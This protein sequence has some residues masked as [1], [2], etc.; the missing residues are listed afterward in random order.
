MVWGTLSN[1]A[2]GG[3]DAG[4][5]RAGAGLQAVDPQAEERPRRERRPP[6]LAPW[7]VGAGLPWAGREG[8]SAVAALRLVNA[9]CF[10]L[11]YRFIVIII[12]YLG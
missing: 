4:R 8:S 9:V 5:R 2:G 1:D 11:P 7:G 3:H 10:R 12:F 6:V